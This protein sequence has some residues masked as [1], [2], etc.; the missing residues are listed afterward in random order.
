MER[1]FCIALV[2]TL[3]AILQEMLDIPL[4]ESET[5]R[6]LNSQTSINSRP[7]NLQIFMLSGRFLNHISSQCPTLPEP[8]AS[9]TLVRLAPQAIP[10]LI[11]K[12]APPVRPLVFLDGDGDSLSRRV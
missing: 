7:T 11:E 2:I 4:R 8:L 9:R 1:A 12:A 10:R 6:A 3:L 5:K